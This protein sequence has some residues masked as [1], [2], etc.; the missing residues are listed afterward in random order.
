M[1][2]DYSI[3]IDSLTDPRIAPYRNL[4]D[5]ELDR[6]GKLFIAEGEYVVRRLLDSDFPVESV[7]VA[8]KHEEEFAQLVPEN[9]EHRQH[10]HDRSRKNP[11]CPPYIKLS[12]LDRRTLAMF[13]Q[14]Q[15]RN[16]IPGND[17]KDSHSQV[18]EGPRHNRVK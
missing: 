2:S 10:E 15:R 8:E 14:Q 11:I 6:A 3:R 7:F 12:Q 16:K 5:K 17:E 9:H 18:C 4:K 1:P 13:L